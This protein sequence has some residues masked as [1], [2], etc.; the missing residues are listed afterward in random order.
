MTGD[1]RE[2]P[3]AEELA[4]WK[5]NW[6]EFAS[7]YPGKHLLIKGSK[8]CG[9]FDNR[10]DAVIVAGERFGVGPIL[11]RSV[12]EPDDILVEIP[13]LLIVG[14]IIDWSRWEIGGTGDSR[15]GCQ[16]TGQADS[17]TFRRQV[18][19]RD[20]IDRYRGESYSD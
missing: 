2:S 8:V 20:R 18:R 14:R 10:R 6:P 16:G 1:K 3:L 7:K 9:V 13:S 19:G 12:D 15:M 4:Y 5:A 11:V 17:I